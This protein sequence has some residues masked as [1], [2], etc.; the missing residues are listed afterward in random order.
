MWVIIGAISVTGPMAIIIGVIGIKRIVIIIGRMVPP[1][2]IHY[3]PKADIN[4]PVSR[5]IAG[6]NILSIVA[7]NINIGGVVYR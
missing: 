3:R 5:G 7:I 2:A 4:P 1:G 6:V